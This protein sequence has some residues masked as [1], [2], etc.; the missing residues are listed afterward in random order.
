MS[1][2]PRRFGLAA[3]ASLILVVVPAGDVHGQDAGFLA[4]IVLDELTGEPLEGATVAILDADLETATSESGAFLLER[5]PLGTLSVRFAA[6]GYA[7]VVERI[8]ISATDFLQVRL[9]PVAVALDELLVVAGRRSRGPDGAEAVE[10]GHDS[11]RSALDLLAD[12]VPG[13][14][15]RRGGGDLGTGAAIAIR[16]VGSFRDSS[17]DVYVDGVRIDDSSGGSRAL[18]ALDLIPAETVARIRVF[19]G[20][21]SAAP[22]ALGANGIIL[23][24]TRRGGDGR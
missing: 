2:G 3:L 15:V 21:S 9:R 22:F 23:I 6:A 19:R 11:W 18:N 8:E 24:E 10:P 4:G 17:P 14:M 16:G 7:S 13:V 1:R 5:I 12:G 20:P